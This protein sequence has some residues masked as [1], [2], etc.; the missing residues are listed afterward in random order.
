MQKLLLLSTLLAACTDQ[1]ASTSNTVAEVR[2]DNGN[3]VSFVDTGDGS[4]AITQDHKMGLEPVHTE[5]M[6]AVGVYR[7]IAPGREV[8]LA[9]SEAQERADEARASRPAKPAT[10]NVPWIDNT[11]IDD[12][13]FVANYCGGSGWDV[14]KCGYNYT[15]AWSWQYNDTDEVYA[16]TCAD[17]GNVTMRVTVDGSINEYDVSQG[18]CRAYHWISGWQNEVVKVQVF[19]VSGTDRYHVA[20]KFAD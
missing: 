17:R 11:T 3:I 8:P 7:A 12:Q 2:L 18:Y 5:N 13:W 15:G 20:A 19:N 9:L 16:V 6:S 1:A 14:I 4:I 10:K